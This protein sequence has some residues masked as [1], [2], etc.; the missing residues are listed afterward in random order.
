MHVS[1]LLVAVFKSC[2]RG[3]SIVSAV[4]LIGGYDCGG[5][6]Q[7]MLLSGTGVSSRDC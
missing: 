5:V 4:I 7:G 6:G 3:C 2:F 1:S